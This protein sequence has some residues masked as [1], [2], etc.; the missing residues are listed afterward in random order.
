MKMGIKEFR[1]RLSE[2]AQRGEPVVV[3]NHGRVLGTFTPFRPKNPERV[4]RAG[5]SIRRWQ[6]SM[7]AKGVDF[8]AELTK[9]GVNAHGEPL[10][11]NA[12]G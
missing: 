1:E 6:E 7:R 8:E 11:D 4:R 10:D 9:M 2:V 5:E 12:R 3:T